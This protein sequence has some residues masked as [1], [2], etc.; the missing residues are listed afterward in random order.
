M[1]GI[2]K[3]MSFLTSNIVGSD[4]SSLLFEDFETSFSLF[5]EDEHAT[6]HNVKTQ[7]SSGASRMM[8][9]VARSKNP[10]HYRNLMQLE[11]IPG[12]CS[13]FTHPEQPPHGLEAE[14]STAPHD[15]FVI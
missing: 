1:N 15:R 13:S 8:N 7:S 5:D 12:H 3:S 4:C 2:Q 6:S 14:H 11:S 10:P 9:D